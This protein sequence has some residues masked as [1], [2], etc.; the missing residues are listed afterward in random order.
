M[1]EQLP[2]PP[3]T[4][5]IHEYA[6]KIIDECVTTSIERYGSVICR[7]MEEKMEKEGFTNTSVRHQL[8]RCVVAAAVM[9]IAAEYLAEEYQLDLLMRKSTDD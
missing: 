8:L 7:A 4:S 6:R 3:V 2:E 9:N 1:E 5:I